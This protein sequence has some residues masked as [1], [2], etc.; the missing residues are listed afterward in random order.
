MGTL[1]FDD[2][3]VKS[4]LLLNGVFRVGTDQR[5]QYLHIEPDPKTR[6][7]HHHRIG[8]Q[9]KHQNSEYT[10]RKVARQVGV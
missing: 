5:G 9:R 2:S 1:G 6:T 8:M 10:T 7:T 4:L 3:D